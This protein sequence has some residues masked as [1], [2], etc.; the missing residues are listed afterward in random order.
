[1]HINYDPAIL[2]FKKKKK[3]SI[4]D[5][6]AAV[7]RLHPTSHTSLTLVLL[8]FSCT[9]AFQQTTT[10]ITNCGFN[11]VMESYSQQPKLYNPK[12][13]HSTQI[14]IYILHLPK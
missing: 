13:T 8:P 3:K 4:W 5:A 11:L 2:N 14:K 1:M 10:K 6:C 9:R 12:Q 7:S